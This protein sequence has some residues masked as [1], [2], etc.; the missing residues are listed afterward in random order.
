M[1]NFWDKFLNDMRLCICIDNIDNSL[2]YE[3][4]Y[5]YDNNQL[6]SNNNLDNNDN[7]NN[8]DNPDYIDYTINNAY[9]SLDIEINTNSVSN[10]KDTIQNH[11][12]YSL[13]FKMLKYKIPINSIKHKL[14]INSLDESIIDLDPNLPIPS[15]LINN[16][17]KNIDPLLYDIINFN[18]HNLVQSNQNEWYII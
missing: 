13:Y 6:N 16:S 7:P 2:E 1:T 10:H 4:D 17:D 14:K 18:K 8:L 9:N 12:I 5:E 15:N 11:K 3:Y